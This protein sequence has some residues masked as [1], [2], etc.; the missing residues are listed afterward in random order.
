MRSH[1]LHFCLA[2]LMALA[3]LTQT[4]AQ[5]KDKQKKGPP[6]PAAGRADRDGEDY[7]QLFKRP[8]NAAEYWNALQFELEVG[9]SEL[10]ADHLRGLIN[11][12]PS[13]A[14]LVKLADEVGVAAF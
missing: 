5:D 1:R 9:K 12:K 7:R 13:D 10:A 8:T 4:S 3:L 6:P 11:S 14:D 2:L